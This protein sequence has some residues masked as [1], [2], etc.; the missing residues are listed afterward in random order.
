MATPV[1]VA[2]NPRRAKRAMN[3]AASLQKQELAHVPIVATLTTWT[4]CASSHRC[5]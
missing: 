1:V 3:H 4:C 2:E 5:C